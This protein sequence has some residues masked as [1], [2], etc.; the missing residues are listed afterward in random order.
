VTA[1]REQGFSLFVC[2]NLLPTPRATAVA[3][4]TLIP[5]GMCWSPLSRG[6]NVVLVLVN[7]VARIQS[8]A[9]LTQLTNMNVL[10][11]AVIIMTDKEHITD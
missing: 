6:K 10:L 3:T 9:S 11:T 5:T 1:F 4:L 7:L 8:L 2:S